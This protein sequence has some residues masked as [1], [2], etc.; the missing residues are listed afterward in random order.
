MKCSDVFHQGPSMPGAHAI[1]RFLVEE[2]IERTLNAH[3][4]DRKEWWDALYGHLH[5]LYSLFPRMCPRYCYCYFVCNFLTAVC[6]KCSMELDYL[7]QKAHR[8][9]QYQ[10][11]IPKSN[12]DTCDLRD[13]S[14]NA[15][16]T[17]K[18]RQTDSFNPWLITSL[19]DFIPSNSVCKY[20]QY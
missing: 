11:T 18:I 10:L 4:K 8:W 7:C 1:E 15:P 16:I 9:S 6:K 3:F 14:A 2:T 19:I 17:V 12:L 13:L 5:I 20:Y